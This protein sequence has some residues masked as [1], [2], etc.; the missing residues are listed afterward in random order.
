M[1]YE[2][3]KNSLARTVIRVL[4]LELD[5]CSH[6]FGQAPCTAS[7]ECCYYTYATCKDPDNYSAGKKEYRFSTAGGPPVEGPLPYLLS[8]KTVPTEIRPREEVTRRARMTVELADDE[9]ATFANPDKNTSLAESFGA[10][11]KNLIARNPNFG[12]RKARVLQGFAGLPLSEYKLCMKGIIETMTAE[13]GKCRVIIKDQLKLLDRKTPPH[14][15]TDNVLQQTYNQDTVIHVARGSEFEA[16]GAVKID[17]EYVRFSGVS[18]NTLTGC[19][20]AAYGSAS[21]SHP[22]GPEVKQV[23]VLADEESG[24]GVA[25]DE[26]FLALLCRE[27]GIS[28]LD[29][30]V[31]SS[32]A[33]LDNHIGDTD[34]AIAVTDPKRFP[35]SG[36][37]RVDDELLLYR[38]VSDAGLLVKER[39][40][41]GTAPAVHAAGTPVDL[42]CF[43]SELGRW[44]SGTKYKRF[45]ESPLPVK[46]LVNE[47]RGQALVHV[48]QAEDSTIAAKAIAPPFYSDAIKTLDDETGLVDGSTSLEPRQKLQTTRISVYYAPQSPAAGKSPEDYN[49]LLKMIDAEAESENYFGRA[50]PKEIFSGF[51]YREHEAM[52]LASRYL[53][54]YG[55]GASVFKFS[56]ELK[57]AELGVG[58]FVAMTSRDIVDFS[59]QARTD[60]LFEVVRKEDRDDNLV[61]Y[62]AVDTGFSRLYPVISPPDLD[63]DYGDAGEQEK[64]RYGWIGDSENRV[65]PDSE[66]GYYI[67]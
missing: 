49:G 3:F 50:K 44:M 33:V 5:Y 34:P 27:G 32:G 45:V 57:D 9:P 31:R 64:R 6:E 19:T 47:L 20:P 59:G 60:A 55:K 24:D 54:R 2:D 46:D 38:G 18:G 7:G 35:T 17:E 10:Y 11:F 48:W 52:L 65:G 1:G 56:T 62:K 25:P 42:T 58:D 36:V 23:T 40:A 13:E 41:Y 66:D 22:A 29:I 28:P 16:P 61:E 21:A 67:Y 8:I 14:I 63:R 37:V 39:G 30:S 43:S 12:G 26:L 51:I 53:A 4:V 15:S